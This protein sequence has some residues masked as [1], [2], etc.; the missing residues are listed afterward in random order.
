M[1]PPTA[2]TTKNTPVRA[3]TQKGRVVVGAAYLA[4]FLAVALVHGGVP[5]LGSEGAWFWAGAVLIVLGSALTEPFFPTPGDAVANGAAAVLAGAA[6]PTT[7]AAAVSL[8]IHQDALAVGRVVVMAYG[9]AVLLL[10]IVVIAVRDRPGSPKNSRPGV[11]LMR[12]VLSSVGSARAVYSVVFLAAAL[13]AFSN[14]LPMLLTVM[15]LWFVVVE[16][17]PLEWIHGRWPT[18]GA[19]LTAPPVATVSALRNPGLV[20]LE[21]ASIGVLQ[22]AG[23]VVADGG[24]TSME[25][26]DTAR[27]AMGTWAL[28][29]VTDGPLP[30]IGAAVEA[31]GQAGNPALGYV[32][33]GTNLKRLVFTV[34]AGL[35]ELTYGDLVTVTFGGREVMYQVVDA[36][37][38]TTPLEPSVQHSRVVVEAVKLG[39]W[40]PG[41]RRF[42]PTLWLPMAGTAVRRLPR[43]SEPLLATAIGHVPGTDFA[44]EADVDV[45]ITHG[46]AVLGVLGSGKSTLA[47]ELML[48][49]MYKGAK[50][51]VIDASPEHAVELDEFISDSP[52]AIA[53]SINAKIGPEARKTGQGPDTGG[54]RKLFERAITEDLEDFLSGDAPLRVYDITKFLV[55]KQT[56]FKDRATQEAD[57]AA[58]T[59]PEVTSHIAVPLLD[60]VKRRTDGRPRVWVVLEEGHQLVPEFSS[61]S[62]K[63]DD[64]A[65]QRTT[66]V[67]LQ[68]RKF[69][70][71]ALLIT[72]RTANVSKSLLTQCNTIFCFRA[73]DDTTAAFLRD[74]AGSAHVAA[75]PNLLDRRVLAFGRA[76]C[77]DP[78][79]LRVNNAG[80]IRAA[81]AGQRP[82]GAPVEGST[83]SAAHAP[84]WD[85]GDANE[86][87]QDGVP[88]PAP[89]SPT[90]AAQP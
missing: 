66:K 20:E 29:A 72:Q 44:V 49:A 32:D 69:G 88:V 60:L 1:T 15:A 19:S 58:C 64:K 35:E 42:S 75:L 54:N 55:T 50:V 90:Q 48:R 84:M 14:D 63:D 21:A 26:I 52:D 23:V 89:A 6:Y 71:G 51:L 10:G 11:V 59:L 46:A 33:A 17:R 22:S 34:P 3:L 73:H 57:H 40:D 81:L 8:G 31:D 37:V 39:G 80:E 24:E 7:A 43:V 68:G 79:F 25:I 13:A 61:I 36:E 2:L 4:A 27:T 62:A 41:R 77:E 86:P 28:A 74:R 5:G 78:L 67:F 53:A 45:L 18:R 85:D 47:R 76:L 65:V 30:A 87:A 70:L 82:T 83:P 38:K 56:T 9:A 16:V 12:A